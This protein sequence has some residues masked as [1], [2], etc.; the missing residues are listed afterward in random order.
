VTLDDQF[1]TTNTTVLKPR[2]FCNPVEKNGEGISDPTAHMMCY[3]IK[4]PKF[5]RQEVVVE[6]QFGQQTLTVLRPYSLCVPAEKDGVPSELSI[7]HMKCYRV[8][9]GP[10]KFPQLQVDLDDQF[11]TKVTTVRKPRMLCTPV[12]KNGEG[13]IAP[14][15]HLTCYS[16]RDAA[17][18]PKFQPRGVDVTDQFAEQDLNTLRGDCRK[19]S[20]LCVPS[21]KRIPS[22]SR[23][24]LDLTTGVMD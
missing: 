14:E 21:T 7:D 20:Y 24:F 22:P 9:Q 17:G 8:A 4:E 12:E 6:N 11:E 13:M 16:I 1:S 5:Q 15:N 10:P 23:A 18:Q 3:K 2:H 19:G